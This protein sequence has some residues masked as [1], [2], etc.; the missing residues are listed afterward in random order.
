MK[1]LILLVGRYGI[2]SDTNTSKSI[3]TMVERTGLAM[4]YFVSISYQ[5]LCFFSSLLLS[6]RASMYE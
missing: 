2:S 4:V 1:F 6:I 3:A 5:A